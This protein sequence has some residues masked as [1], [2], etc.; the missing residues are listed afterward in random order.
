MDR[1][2]TAA[3]FRTYSIDRPAGICS[4]RLWKTLRVGSPDLVRCATIDTFERDDRG[5]VPLN[6]GGEFAGAPTSRMSTL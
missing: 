6:A 4:N 1:G 5:M 3:T 2:A